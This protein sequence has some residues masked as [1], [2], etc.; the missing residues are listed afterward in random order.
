VF[1]PAADRM[2]R[3]T[4][5]QLVNTNKILVQLFMEKAK[6]PRNDSE[7]NESPVEI[8]LHPTGHAIRNIETL[9][10]LVQSNYPQVKF[11]SKLDW[12]KYKND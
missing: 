3:S 6:R 11:W 9:P 1:P 5:E 10:L 8:P 4:L 7:N 2:H 12:K